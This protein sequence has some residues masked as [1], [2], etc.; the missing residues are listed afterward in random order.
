MAD[1]LDVSWLVHAC[2][3]LVRGVARV[4][5]RVAHTGTVGAGLR[6]LEPGADGQ[7]ARASLGVLGRC[8]ML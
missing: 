7:E 5:A 2:Q 6:A 1:G 3:L 4:K 8:D